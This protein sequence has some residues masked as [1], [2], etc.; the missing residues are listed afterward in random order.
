M[1]DGNAVKNRYIKIAV[2]S[3]V[4][5]IGLMMFGDYWIPK[6]ITQEM[7]L[8]DAHF[9]G[10]INHT[11][12]DLEARIR[13]GEMIMQDNVPFRLRTDSADIT[14]TKMPEEKKGISYVKYRVAIQFRYPYTVFPRK[15][16]L[17]AIL[18]ATLLG[19]DH[20]FA[21]LFWSLE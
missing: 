10:G 13:S 17:D 16:K 11:L 19:T 4:S 5:C 12:L 2:F 21:D 18:V 9:A 6:K 3:I 7:I 8:N 15:T 1:N 20:V 14:V